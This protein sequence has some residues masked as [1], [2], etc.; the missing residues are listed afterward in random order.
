MTYQVNKIYL[1]NL[2][3]ERQGRRVPPLPPNVHPFGSGMGFKFEDMYHRI[4]KNSPYRRRYGPFNEYCLPVQGPPNWHQLYVD[5]SKIGQDYQLANAK[6]LPLPDQQLRYVKGQTPDNL[7]RNIKFVRELGS[8][9]FGSVWE[10]TAK[11]N[12]APRAGYFK[13]RNVRLACKVMRY[14]S[15]SSSFR[16]RVE[17]M[18]TDMNQL[19]YLRHNNIVQFIDIIGIPDSQTG[20]P[21]SSILIMMDKCDGDLN[22]LIVS[23]AM[24]QQQ[25]IAWLRQIAE[26]VRYLHFDE[27]MVHLDIKPAN[28]LYQTNGG[29]PVNQWQYKLAD[30]GLAIVYM[31]KLDMHSKVN[32]GSPLYK[33][34]EMSIPP[35][36]VYTPLCDVYSLGATVASCL[37][38]RP[39]YNGITFRQELPQLH[40][41]QPNMPAIP[42][43]LLN[44]VNDMTQMFVWQRATIHDVCARVQQL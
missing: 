35:K 22:S 3:S 25:T 16:R 12:K 40:I 31:D 10:I 42:S 17:A 38:G 21:Y 23:R 8:G 6:G 34:P 24:S 44:L 43:E 2:E 39:Y 26:A 5:E 9:G 20:F 11:Q 41:N 1:Q 14:T 30:F 32:R 7:W 36:E 15:G 37:L 28:I 18:L 13:W 27:I 29:K 19:R 33:P 4:N